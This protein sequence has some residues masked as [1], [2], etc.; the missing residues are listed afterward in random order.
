MP[1]R[2]V[3]ADGERPGDGD[4][5]QKTSARRAVESVAVEGDL[6][7]RVDLGPG[8]H[9]RDEHA[10]ERGVVRAA[11]RHVIAQFRDGGAVGGVHV[12]A[13]DR[14]GRARGPVHARAVAEER[15]FGD[16]PAV[17]VLVV[18]RAVR[19]MRREAEVAR[20]QRGRAGRARR[21]P[22]EELRR[23]RRERGRGPDGA[24]ARE[25]AAGVRRRVFVRAAPILR[26]RGDDRPDFAVVARL[27]DP[28]RRRAVLVRTAVRRVPTVAGEGDAGHRV[29]RHRRELCRVVLLVA[30][31]DEAARRGIT[32]DETLQRR[33]GVSAPRRGDRRARGPRHHRA[34]GVEQ[35][36]VAR[37]PVEVPGVLVRRTADHARRREADVAHGL[38][39]AFGT[40]RTA[41]LQRALLDHGRAR[42]RGFL[43]A[44]RHRAR[45]TLDESHR[46]LPVREAQ[47]GRRCCLI[48]EQRHR[49]CARVLDGDVRVVALHTDGLRGAA[50]PRVQQHARHVLTSVRVLEDEGSRPVGHIAR[51]D[52]AAILETDISLAR[53]RAQLKRLQRGDAHVVRAPARQLERRPRAERFA[54]TV[55][56]RE[57]VGLARIVRETRL[58][59]ILRSNH[60][61][62]AAIDEEPP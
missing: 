30:V 10:V 54:R 32:V 61:I 3:R 34:R 41:D 59:D 9:L 26:T 15:E 29:D 38:R 19:L 25:R 47:T 53:E 51:R 42:V 39:E 60:L 52:P 2:A 28:A 31:E 50:Q 17:A 36:D 43:D 1:G 46:S 37:A 49:R 11:G 14:C 57:G 33:R 44:E 40:Q 18:Q 6:L 24:V 13:G 20:L 12:A 35:L 5:V 16:H 55:G 23:Q 21:R 22:R 45:T 7:A 56:R 27:K 62:F 8:R 48:D 58:L 4:A